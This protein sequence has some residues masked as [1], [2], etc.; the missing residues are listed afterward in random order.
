MQVCFQP[1]RGFFPGNY[2]PLAKIFSFYVLPYLINVDRIPTG[3]VW[4][5]QQLEKESNKNFP[6][7]TSVTV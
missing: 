1:L 5:F 6:K 4:A 2:K 7:C 3:L